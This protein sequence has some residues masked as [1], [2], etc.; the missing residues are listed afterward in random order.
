MPSCPPNQP[1]CCCLSPETLPG[2]QGLQLS[3]WGASAALGERR[4]ELGHLSLMLCTAKVFSKGAGTLTLPWERAGLG[5]SVAPQPSFMVFT[6]TW[7]FFFPLQTALDVGQSSKTGAKCLWGCG[8][9]RGGRCVGGFSPHHLTL[10]GFHLF[11]VSSGTLGS[12]FPAGPG[13]PGADGHLTA[14]AP[15]RGEERMPP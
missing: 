7:A 6:P 10:P 5:P 4:T 14:A 9:G 3:C 12:P 1:Q 13:L 15:G 8:P 11:V 2:L